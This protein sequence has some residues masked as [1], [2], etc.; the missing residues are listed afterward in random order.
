MLYVTSPPPKFVAL[1]SSRGDLDID[2]ESQS[3]LIQPDWLGAP[4]CIGGCYTPRLVSDTQIS[5]WNLH[6]LFV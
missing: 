2:I 1:G 3:R 4:N 6:A 5:V